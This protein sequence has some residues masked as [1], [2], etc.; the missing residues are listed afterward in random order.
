MEKVPGIRTASGAVIEV[1]LFSCNEL[2]VPVALSGSAA[3][4]EHCL[5][6]LKKLGAV[7]D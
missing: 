4:V 6:E 1:G 2:V 7:V 3:E 5:D